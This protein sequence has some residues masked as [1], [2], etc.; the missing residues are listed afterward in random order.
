MGTMLGAL[1]GVCWLGLLMLIIMYIYGV[2][3]VLIFKTNDPKYFGDLS[4]ALLTLFRVSESPADTVQG[5]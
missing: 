4:Q 5:E 2:I 3:G 1:P